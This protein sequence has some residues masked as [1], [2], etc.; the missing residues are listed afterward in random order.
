VPARVAAPSAPSP[1]VSAEPAEKAAPRA[2]AAFPW[3]NA[4]LT[5]PSR[6][7]RPETATCLSS[8]DVDELMP[9]WQAAMDSNAPKRVTILAFSRY[10][11]GCPCYEQYRFAG[12]DIL[13]F[14]VR[15][16]PSA[17]SLPPRVHGGAFTLTGYF[18]GRNIDTY[19]WYT[20]LGMPDV[21][22]EEGADYESLSLEFV[23]EGYCFHPP[24]PDPGWDELFAES[25]AEM[26]RLGVPFCK[27]ENRCFDWPKALPTGTCSRELVSRKAH[28][29]NNRGLLE[30]W[31]AAR[32][33]YFLGT[34]SDPHAAPS[35]SISVETWRDPDPQLLAARLGAKSFDSG[36]EAPYVDPFVLD[37]SRSW[38][39][40]FR[41]SE[42]AIDALPRVLCD[43]DVA[44]GYLLSKKK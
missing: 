35:D 13:P 19:D 25:S 20:A 8:L 17:D 28:L 26:R 30:E 24:A 12:G 14:F 39:L 29:L 27:T 2:R 16:L 15:G 43:P 11:G 41:N 9:D 44:S 34:P 1:T 22:P 37:G 21:I 6:I 5:R 36:D 32:M 31:D 40:H 4:A 10:G 33:R 38:V 3:L 18:T 23:V 42:S 7:V